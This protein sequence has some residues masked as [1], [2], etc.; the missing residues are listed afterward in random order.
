MLAGTKPL[1][2][3][4]EVAGYCDYFPEDEFAPH[5]SSG[6]I[7]RREEL[8]RHLVGGFITRCLY[9][10]LPSHEWRM[11][12]AHAIQKAIFT[13]SR[14]GSEADDVRLG[15]LLGY[16]REEISAFMDHMRRSRYL[17]MQL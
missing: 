17:R 6:R 5:V 8:Y 10:A 14:R 15:Q 11:E 1:A 4:C 3:F 13:G 16:S 2:M 7:V 9:Y 12:A